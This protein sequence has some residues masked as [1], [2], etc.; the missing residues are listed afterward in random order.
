M[1]RDEIAGD[2]ILLACNNHSRVSFHQDVVHLVKIY[3]S[4]ATL[5]M[6]HFH[7]ITDLLVWSSD[8][9]FRFRN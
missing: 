9:Q 1:P 7:P 3:I 5:P 2:P 6:F 4:V 8:A